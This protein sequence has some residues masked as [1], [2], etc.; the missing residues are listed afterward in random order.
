MADTKEEIARVVDVIGKMIY[1]KYQLKDAIDATPEH[2][3]NK[4]WKAQVEFIGRLEA[5]HKRETATAEKSSAVGDAA[6][7]REAVVAMVNSETMGYNDRDTLCGRCINKLHGKCKHDG[8]CW[9]DKIM[10]ALAAPP[11][12]CDVGT[13]E[14]QAERFNEFCFGVK[15]AECRAHFTPE[16]KTEAK[17]FG[18]VYCVTKWAQMP[19]EEGGAE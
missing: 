3:S 14:E 4:R 19:Y 12:N 9:V 6:K 11:R 15:C 1:R 16:H 2:Y 18:R 5:A 8:S 10:T 13:A 7:L 17:R